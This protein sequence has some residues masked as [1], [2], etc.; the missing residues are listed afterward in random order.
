MVQ[1][2]D[3][4]EFKNTIFKKLSFDEYIPESVEFTVY[5]FIKSKSK[6]RSRLFKCNHDG[7]CGKIIV[8]V[9]KLFSHIMSHTQE[10][11]YNCTFPGCNMTFGYKGNL[12]KHYRGTH[13]GI[14]KYNCDHCGKGYTKK[15]NLNKHLASVK[16]KELLKNQPSK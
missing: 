15:F 4:Q 3:G 2:Y 11:P 5:E 8:S 9:S 7:E 12:H 10:K 6:K 14:K 13:E 1:E 16:R